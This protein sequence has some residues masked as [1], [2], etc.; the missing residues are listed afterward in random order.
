MNKRSR[1]STRITSFVA[2]GPSIGLSAASLEDARA[3]VAQYFEQLGKV[4]Q[5]PRLAST[6]G[7]SA[8][9]P[10]QLRIY[11][12]PGAGKKPAILSIFTAVALS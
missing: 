6:A 11:T 10:V 9:P 1:G 5:R 3:T 12:P 8:A 2:N 7:T 4:G